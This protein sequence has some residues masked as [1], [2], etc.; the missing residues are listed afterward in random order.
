[1]ELGDCITRIKDELKVLNDELGEV[2]ERLAALETDIAWVKRLV[3][4]ILSGV[5]AL[6]VKVYLS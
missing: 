4:V 5:I 3:W 2:V 1:M 6:L